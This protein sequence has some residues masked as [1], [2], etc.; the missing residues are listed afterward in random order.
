MIEYDFDCKY[1]EGTGKGYELRDKDTSGTY[2]HELDCWH[3]SFPK[4]ELE[5]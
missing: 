2:W 1:C 4:L 3:C 5:K